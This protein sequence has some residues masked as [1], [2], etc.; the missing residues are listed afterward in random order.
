MV[1]IPAKSWVVFF[2][3][4]TLGLI[5]YFSYGKQHSRLNK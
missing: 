2:G 1:E 4:M 5:I 3:W